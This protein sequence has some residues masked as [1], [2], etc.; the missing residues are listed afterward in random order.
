MESMANNKSVRNDGLT[1]EFYE[2][3]WNEVKEPYIMSIKKVFHK[4][5]F[6]HFTG[7]SY[8][9]THKKGSRQTA[10]KKLATNYFTKHRHKNIIKSPV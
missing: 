5:S 10:C 9:Q 4:K 8:N 7:T 6:K 1:R 3:F 2:I